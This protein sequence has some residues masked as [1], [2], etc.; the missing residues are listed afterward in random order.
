MFFNK[1]KPAQPRHLKLNLDSDVRVEL[2]DSVHIDLHPAFVRPE[3]PFFLQAIGNI[4]DG[5]DNKDSFTLYAE[6]NDNAYLLEIEARADHIEAAALYQNILTLN[7]G[8]DEWETLMQDITARDID[9]DGIGF[10]R[11]LGGEAANAPLC[12]LQEHIH[13]PTEDY[14][15]LNKVMLFTR[16]ITPGNFTEQLKVV[17]EVM[18]SRQQ[19]SVSFYLGFALPPST[20]TIL[21]N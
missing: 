20:L 14:D 5:D 10:L 7:P 12:E 13:T 17:V 15:C 8:E 4:E 9:L 6:N 1:P 3:G 16:T 2:I 18:E 21:G 19:A 11:A